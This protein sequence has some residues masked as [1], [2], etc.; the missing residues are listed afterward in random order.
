MAEQGRG[1][2]LIVEDDENTRAAF[3][4]VLELAGW[5][6]DEAAGGEE[7][8][9][10]AG[11]RPPEIAL[12]DISIPGLDGWE[13]TR[14]LK[15]EP[16]TANVPVI[17]V[18]GHALDRDRELAREAGCDGYLVKPIAPRQLL[19]EIERLTRPPG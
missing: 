16:A 14:R 2:V 11:R 3:R 1:R 9:R 17:A 5:A 6:V 13:T 10:V 18:T 15:G 8:L 4:T 19:A 7:A 12:V